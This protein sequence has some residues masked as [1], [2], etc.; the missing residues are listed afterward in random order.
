[1][2]K[3]NMAL[4]TLTAMNQRQQEQFTQATVLAIGV[5]MKKV[6]I[7]EISVGPEDFTKLL[8]GEKVTV[9]ELVGGGF[10]YRLTQ[11]PQPASQEG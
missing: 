7:N 2:R 6:G 3:H 4:E 5:V 8:P 1:M 11:R 10:T 9:E